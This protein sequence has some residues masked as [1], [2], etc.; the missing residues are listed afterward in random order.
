MVPMDGYPVVL[1][2]GAVATVLILG[3]T[4]LAVRRIA[5]VLA[6]ALAGCVVASAL[7]PLGGAKGS[8]GGE[9]VRE[10][11][12]VAT[13]ALVGALCLLRVAAVRAERAAWLT[14]GW[15]FALIATA[16]AVYFLVV[17]HRDPL[18]YPSV[19][20]ALWISGYV[21][22][23]VFLLQLAARR[24]RRVPRALW[25]DG[26]VAALAVAAVGA[27]VFLPTAS[28]E[29]GTAA[30]ATSLAYPVADV[31]LITLVVG[32]FGVSGWRP[33][34]GWGLIGAAFTL[35]VV[36]DGIY[37]HLVA[38]GTYTPG[39]ILDLS[40]QLSGLALC[41]A[42]WELPGRPSEPAAQHGRASL[43]APG[44][45]TLL[46]LG[47]VV[48]D[49]FVTVPSVTMLLAISALTV[50][51]L[52]T[53]TMFGDA[54]SLAAREGALK[55]Y[56]AIL[57]AAGEGICMLDPDDRVTFANPAAAAALGRSVED[58]LGRA[59]AELTGTALVVEAG[60]QTRSA[61]FVRVDGTTFPVDY[62]CTPVV[63]DGEALGAA[64]V[65]HGISDRL[66]IERLA[67]ARH[68]V[69]AALAIPGAPETTPTAAM[70][71]V[72]DALGWQLGALWLTADDQRSLQ[73]SAASHPGAVPDLART[74]PRGEGAA[75]GVWTQ[76]A[77]VWVPH[78]GEDARLAAL[79]PRRAVLVPVMTD[80]RLLGALG[81][82]ADELG[83][84]AGVK[85]ETLTTIAGYVAHYLERL[86][87]R[88]ELAVARD[89]ALEASRLKSE[90]LANMS[91]EIRTPLNGV[92]G[93]TELLLDTRLD[94]EQRGFSEAIHSSGEALLG[95]VNDVLDF[96]KIEAGHLEIEVAA[97]DIRE[98]V[99]D[100]MDMLGPR[101]RA[102]GLELVV[103]VDD[104]VPAAVKTDAARFRQILTNLV[105]NAVKFTASGDVL[106]RVTAA[107]A[108]G[109]VRLRTEVRDTGIG[110]ASEQTD[111]LFDPFSQAD[112]STTR[113]YGGTGLGLAISRRLAKMLGG[114]IGATGEVGTGSTF[115]FTITA[116]PAEAPAPAPRC[117][118]MERLHVLV[119]DDHP[120]NR[121]ILERQ[122]TSWGMSVDIFS[123]PLRALAA[124]ERSSP[125][126][127]RHDLAIVDY[128]MAGMDGV[129]LASRLA[130]L[131]RPEPLPVLLL[132][133]AELDRSAARAAGV[134]DCLM[135]P[136]RQSRLYDAIATA[137]VGVRRPVEPHQRPAADDSGQTI[138]IADDNPVNQA[139][140]AESLR[141][142]GFDVIVAPDGQ[143]ALAE[144]ERTTFAAVLMDCQM[145]ELDGYAATREIRRR[146]HGGRRTPVIAMTAHTLTGD[147]ERC[148]SADMDDYLGKPLRPDQLD[149]VLHRWVPRAKSQ[150]A[151]VSGDRRE[152]VL[153]ASVLDD[154]RDQLGGAPL[155]RDV[156]D[157]FLADAPRRVG[158]L[159]DAVATDDP[160]RARDA[161]HA[162]N[163]QALQFGAFVLSK[164]ARSAELAAA[165]NDLAGAGTALT[166]VETA[167]ES[168]VAALRA[169]VAS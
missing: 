112:A 55:R 15:S 153:D 6:V 58:L 99:D 28:T 7:G 130:A 5:A 36:A 65:F 22:Y 69:A 109:H 85:S 142:R 96:S 52:R 97:F 57:D 151:A 42:A 33:G 143:A 155:L 76:R 44:A 163:G 70:R 124:A 120:I 71:A 108:G 165:D 66:R 74:L 56:G 81:F 147:R 20:D 46:A 51:F 100:T 95:I 169:E 116:E 32:V 2:T 67:A 30:I 24:I 159:R 18:P 131:P 119:V 83:L 35:Q 126:A 110:I 162:L 47:V 161:A 14:L 117:P 92:I 150:P 128:S 3:Q 122:L 16:W 84:G 89:R 34:R 158:Q 86:R 87:V 114:E 125:S 4:T 103:D 13:F 91:H 136:V 43:V 135:K 145:P 113:Q 156:V 1:S 25:L 94:A 107:A 50:G 26:V 45:F 157:L 133:S 115:W 40:W 19:S 59:A 12:Y 49:Q 39:T 132:T 75:G 121:T 144:M 90:F 23:F 166:E 134:S 79:G 93:M 149:A 37:L 41:A 118:A 8:L 9:G 82:F 140:A 88:R 146:E 60:G 154:L 167:L 101:A 73:L 160:G 48:F 105:G 123:D 129:E 27:A 104:A 102:K 148:L 21:L 62:T 111:R 53:A 152:G 138:L 11:L 38:A 54:R 164:H 31:V 127:N 68:G 139:V 64:V 72:C 63:E 141:R 61:E 77:P 78:V 80:D 29:G 17:Q 98:A 10:L 137:A 106:V 168:T